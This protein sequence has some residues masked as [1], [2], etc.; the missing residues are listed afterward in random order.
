MI[1]TDGTLKDRN[2]VRRH[3]PIEMIEHWVI[4][5]SGIMLIIT[6]LLELPVG[7]RYYITD[8]P[9][10]SWAGDFFITL[11]LHYAAAIVFVAATFFH[12]FYHGLRGDSGLLPR[13]GDLKDSIEVIKSFFGKGEEPPFEK[14]LPEQRLAYAGMAVIIAL[15][16]LSGL[17][18]TYMNLLDP[19]LSRT[20]AL[21]ATWTHNIAFFL[22]VLAFIAHIAALVIKPNRPLVRG[23]FTGFIRL[24]YALKRHSLWIGKTMEKDKKAVVKDREQENNNHSTASVTAEADEQLTNRKE[25]QES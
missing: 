17:V 2:L 21:A 15:L 14:Y 3:R 11:S 23:M 19:Q 20:I 1:V 12:L 5:L 6:G 22:F 13:R 24:D 7:R 4:A 8:I 16:I 9:C 18:K 10:F 25:K